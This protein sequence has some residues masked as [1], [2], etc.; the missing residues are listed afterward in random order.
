M[1]F[2]PGEF[3]GVRDISVGGDAFGF[4]EDGNRAYMIR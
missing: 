2:M 4:C 3:M 1:V